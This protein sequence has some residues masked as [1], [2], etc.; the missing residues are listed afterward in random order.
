MIY[1]YDDVMNFIIQKD[2]NGN[3]MIYKYDVLGCFF[4]KMDV[5][6]YIIWYVYD[7]VN[8]WLIVDCNGFEM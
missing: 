2:L 5:G 6:G 1:S 8:V 3:Q 7:G 4:L